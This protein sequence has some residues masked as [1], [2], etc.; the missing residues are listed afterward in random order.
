MHDALA[1]ITCAPS[2]RYQAAL[3]SA[4]A[5]APQSQGVS[6]AVPPIKARGHMSRINAGCSRR[7][8][9]SRASPSPGACPF[10]ALDPIAENSFLATSIILPVPRCLPAKADPCGSSHDCGMPATMPFCIAARA[11]DP[12][13]R[14][15]IMY[16]FQGW[17]F[18]DYG[19]ALAKTQ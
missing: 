12:A 19:G 14:S 1:L 11:P 5:T 3:T 18:I 9:R 17:V 2:P 7:I 4:V 13:V 10:V 15:V 16:K 6:S 8:D